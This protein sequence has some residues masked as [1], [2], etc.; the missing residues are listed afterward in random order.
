MNPPTLPPLGKDEL[1]Y[2]LGK[3]SAQ[4]Q[5]CGQ[6]EPSLKNWI[7]QRLQIVNQHVQQL[8]KNMF[9][10]DAFTAMYMQH[11]ENQLAQKKAGSVDVEVEEEDDLKIAADEVANANANTTFI[12]TAQAAGD[13]ACPHPMVTPTSSV[14]S[15]PSDASNKDG[16]MEVEVI[17]KTNGG[18]DEEEMDMDVDEKSA[19]DKAC[20]EGGEVSGTS[21][22]AAVGCHDVDRFV[23]ECCAGIGFIFDDDQPTAI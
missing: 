7:Q 14:V 20:G 21:D 12:D 6:I 15:D 11:Q 10:I 9:T 1:S 16:A 2:L 17:G 23:E 13:A 22:G 8:Q 19:G 3:V 4:V 5:Y 18:A